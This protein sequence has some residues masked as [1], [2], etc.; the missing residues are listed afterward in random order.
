LEDMDK[1]E[2]EVRARCLLV[3]RCCLS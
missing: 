1:A 3:Q 2:Q